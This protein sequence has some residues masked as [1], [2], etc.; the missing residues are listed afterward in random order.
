[1]NKKYKLGYSVDIDNE[2]ILTKKIKKKLLKKT[3]I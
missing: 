2:D 1:M 3:K